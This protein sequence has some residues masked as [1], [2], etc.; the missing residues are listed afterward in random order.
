MDEI[1]VVSKT[2][3]AIVGNYYAGEVDFSKPGPDF[4]QSTLIHLKVPGELSKTLVKCVLING[5][6]CIQ[7]DDEKIAKEVVAQL[8]SVKIVRNQLLMSSDWTQF[9]DS[10]LTV[11]QQDAW[12]AYRKALRD[13]P[14]NTADPTQVVWPTPPS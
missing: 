12:A 9:R 6:Y 5:E 7:A 3:L 2:T 8:A 4:D 1:L 13:L 10:P 14:A 11:E